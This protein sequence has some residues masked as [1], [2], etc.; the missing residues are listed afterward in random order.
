MDDT[1]FSL[2]GCFSKISEI[3]SVFKQLAMILVHVSWDGGIG[4]P[5]EKLS[6]L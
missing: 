5:I 2:S 1:I 6:Y 3:A 4:L